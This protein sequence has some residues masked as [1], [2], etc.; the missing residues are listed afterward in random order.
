MKTLPLKKATL[1]TVLLIIMVASGTVGI[2]SARRQNWA[3]RIYLQLYEQKLK[4]SRNSKS[5]SRNRDRPQGQWVKARNNTTVSALSEEQKK[6]IT[7]LSALP[8]LKGYSSAPDVESVTIYNK[9]F[10]YS[11]INFVLSADGPRAFLMDMMGNVLHEWHIDFKDVWPAPFDDWSDPYT[12]YWKRARLLSKGDLLA[13]FTNY[14]LIKLDK[15]SKLLWSYKARCHHDMFE[16]NNGNIY[17]LTHEYK[18]R[19][20]LNSNPMSS[21][22]PCWKILS[23]S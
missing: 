5:C 11:G 9:E 1:V 23:R 15:N 12:E 17:V 18:N 19:N 10:A 14:G 20:I 22:S 16:T 3:Y 4:L 6:A 13:I 2:M 21:K 7:E 8:Y